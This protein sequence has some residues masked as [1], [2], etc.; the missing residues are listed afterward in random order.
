L[1]PL[2]GQ[3]GDEFCPESGPG[4]DRHLA[5]WFAVMIKTDFFIIRTP[6]KVKI[7]ENIEIL[8]M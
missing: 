4:F 1:I 7:L 5:P 2:Q 3:T 6:L 8:K